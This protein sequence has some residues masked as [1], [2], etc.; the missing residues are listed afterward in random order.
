MK[1]TMSTSRFFLLS[2][3]LVA[4]ATAA[5]GLGRRTRRLEKYQLEEGLRNWEDEGGNLAP[6]ADQAVP[7]IAAPQ[8]VGPSL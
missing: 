6:P 4:S 5:Y 7:S 1:K 8:S 3:A 2:L